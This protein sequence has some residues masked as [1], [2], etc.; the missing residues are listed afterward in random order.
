MKNVCQSLLLLD[1]MQ[2]KVYVD[3]NIL[4]MKKVKPPK[5]G[6]TKLRV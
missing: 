1:K 5:G 4:N 3:I 2:N 6:D